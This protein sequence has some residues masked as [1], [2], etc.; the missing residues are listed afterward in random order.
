MKLSIVVGTTAIVSLAAGSA[1]GYFIALKILEKKYEGRLQEEVE[2]TKKFYA[3][4]YKKDE[5]QT[6]ESTMKEIAPGAAEAAA[7]LINYQGRGSKSFEV[8]DT[9]KEFVEEV[10][11]NIFSDTTTEEISEKEKRDRTEEAPYILTKDEFME[12]DS[13]YTQSTV[14]YFG[15][16][17]VLI[18][19]RED[20][21]EE[22]DMTVGEGNLE[23]FGHGSGDPNVLYVRNDR[24]EL[25][26]EILLSRGKYSKEVAGLEE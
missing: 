5:F 25:E 11:S 21:I 18:D 2:S 6:P 8:V 22:V 19:S 14:T 1:A 3:K 10:L 23:R 9:K 20:M 26:F 4:L 15:G 16:D 7:A 24:L 17:K 12:N 13:E